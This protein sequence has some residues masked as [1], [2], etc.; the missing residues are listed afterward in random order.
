MIGLTKCN[1]NKVISSE[2]K[3]VMLE[4]AAHY[5]EQFMLALG[6][7]VVNDDN[8][9]ETP[10]RVAKMYINELFKGRYEE[11]PEIKSFPNTEGYDQIIFTNC[12]IIGVCAHHHVPIACQVYIGVLS[13]PEPSSKLIGLS[14]Y[15]RL[16]EWVGSRPTI[17]EDMTNQIHKEIDK[18]CSDN[19]G[20]MVYV[21]GSHGCTTYRGVKQ[22]GSKMITSKVSGA[23][24][25]NQSIKEEFFTMVKN[26]K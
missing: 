17:Q 1:E 18:V 26:S 10:K 24:K 20:V 9:K 22:L 7:D 6:I 16:A 25:Q 4:E 23:F 15:T 8:S 13:N 5:Y 3:K 2:K 12:E 21:I 14:K 11:K 19:K